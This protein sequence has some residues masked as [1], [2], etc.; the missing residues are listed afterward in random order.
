MALLR[1][2]HA[3]SMQFISNE[4]AGQSILRIP[5]STR[6]PCTLRA[7]WGR[8]LLSCSMNPSPAVFAKPLT[9]GW[10][11][12]FSYTAAV[13]FPSIGTSGVR[14][15][16]MTPAQN[17]IEP[18]NCWWRSMVIERWFCSP[19]HLHMRIELL[20]GCRPILTSSENK[21]LVRLSRV[22]FSCA[23][24]HLARAPLWSGRSAWS[25]EWSLSIQPYVMKI[26]AHSLAT[27]INTCDF[28]Q[29]MAQSCSWDYR[30]PM[31]R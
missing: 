8:A 25:L 31:C 27:Y 13:M 11:M 9:M 15:P 18:P 28:V 5:C 22:Q 14:R 24:A 1:K 30:V 3:C 20:S 16:N 23:L 6:Y 2:L 10:R 12:L 17:M 19:V 29:L 4:H 21:V 26:I 7:R